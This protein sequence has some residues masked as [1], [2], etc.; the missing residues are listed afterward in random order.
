ADMPARVATPELVLPVTEDRKFAIVQAVVDNAAF[1]A[2]PINTL[3][4]IRVDFADGWGLLRASNTG[5][6]LIL[7]F[8]AVHRPALDRVLGLFSSALA[9]VSPELGPALETVAK[10]NR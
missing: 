4:G 3:D 8:E 7:R 2:G 6:N 9:A 5:P 1:G 10:A